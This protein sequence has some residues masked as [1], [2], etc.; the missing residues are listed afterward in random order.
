MDKYDPFPRAYQLDAIAQEDDIVPAT[1]VKVDPLFDIEEESDTPEVSTAPPLVKGTPEYDTWKKTILDKVRHDIFKVREEETVPEAVEKAMVNMVEELVSAFHDGS[2]SMAVAEFF[3][4]IVLTTKVPVVTKARP[5]VAAQKPAM[6][7]E[8]QKMEQQKV[9]LPS[10]SNYSSPVLLVKK[11]DGTIRFCIDYRRLNSITVRD[12]YPLPK[13]DSM[14]DRLGGSKYFASFDCQSGYHQIR[15]TDRASKVSA[16]AT[17]DGLFEWVCMPFGLTNAPATFQRSMD[18]ALS[19]VSR[20]CAMVYIDDVLVHSSSQ[21]EHIEN[22]QEVL[23]CFQRVNLKLKLSKCTFFATEV[24]FLGHVIGRQGIKMDPEKIE[25]VLNW[26]IPTSVKELQSFLGLVNY[27]RDFVKR[28]AAL[29]QPLYAL[30]AT[31]VGK[32]PKFTEIFLEEHVKAFEELRIAVTTGPM[33]YYPD[34]AKPFRL[35]SDAHPHG[36]AAILSQLDGEG[37]DRPIAFASSAMDSGMRKRYDLMINQSLTATEAECLGMIFGMRHFRSYLYG[38][39]FHFFTDHVAL[40]WIATIKDPSGKMARWLATIQEMDF[41]IQHVPGKSIQHCDALSRQRHPESVGVLLA[42]PV[43]GPP[44]VQDITGWTSEQFF[45]TAWNS[46]KHN[47]GPRPAPSDYDK[48]KKVKPVQLP[49][50]AGK[51]YQITSI[52]VETVVDVCELNSI[53]PPDVAFWTRIEE[54]PAEFTPPAAHIALVARHTAYADWNSAARNKM[55]LM[56]VTVIDTPNG[57]EI[58]TGLEKW[59][60]EQCLRVLYRPQ[61]ETQMSQ[62]AVINM[63]EKVDDMIEDEPEE[64]TCDHTKAQRDTY[65]TIR[66]YTGAS[67][68]NGFEARYAPS[69]H[70]TD[71][72]TVN[73]STTRTEGVNML[74]QDTTNFRSKLHQIYKEAVQQGYTVTCMNFEGQIDGL[75]QMEMDE[76]P[77]A[78]DKPPPAKNSSTSGKKASQ[79]SEIPKVSEEEKIELGNTAPTENE[80]Y[81]A[82]SRYEVEHL[83][84]LQATDPVFGVIVQYLKDIKINDKTV[85]DLQG[86]KKGVANKL[87]L[88]L[89]QYILGPDNRLWYNENPS[90]IQEIGAQSKLCIPVCQVERLLDSFHSIGH[91]GVA[92]TN[93]AIRARFHWWGMVR[94]IKKHAEACTLCQKK[95]GLPGDYGHMEPI[96][97]RGRAMLV[98]C[99]H[100]GPLLETVHGFLH[101]L[102]FT[103]HF[104]RCVE[105]VAVKDLEAETT[106]RAFIDH[107]VLRWGVPYRL[108]TDQGTTYTSDT[109]RALCKML[110]VEKIFTTAQHPQANGKTE[111]YNRTMKSILAKMVDVTMRN[112]DEKLPTIQWAYNTVIHPATGFTPHFL[113]YGFEP[114][115]PADLQYELE[116][117][118]YLPATLRES[119][120]LMEETYAAAVAEANEHATDT[121]TEAMRTYNESHKDPD[122][123]FSVGKE[124]WFYAADLAAPQKLLLPWIGPFTIKERVSHNTF[125]LYDVKTQTEF[126]SLVS[127]RRLK[128]YIRKFRPVGA[129]PTVSENLSE[130]GFDLRKENKNASELISAHQEFI[131]NRRS[132]LA[133]KKFIEDAK[134]Q[135]KAIAENK[136]TAAKALKE[137]KHK[138]L[139]KKEIT[140]QTTAKK[141]AVV[142]AAEVIETHAAQRY[143]KLTETDVASEIITTIPVVAP[144]AMETST[145]SATVTTEAARVVPTSS[146]KMTLQ[147]KLSDHNESANALNHTVIRV[148]KPVTSNNSKLGS[149]AMK[150]VSFADPV[151]SKEY[152]NREYQDSTLTSTTA[153]NSKEHGTSDL[154]KS[155]AA[156]RVGMSDRWLAHSAKFRD[157]RE[158]SMEEAKNAT[159]ERTA[160]A[161]KFT[162]QK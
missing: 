63:V 116:I 5:V 80:F 77:T 38:R 25:K 149:A 104:S 70:I 68:T 48:E 73:T 64:K 44:L 140:A 128:P 15:L 101:I 88:T 99:D 33:L 142:K 8:M 123:H 100:A 117:D 17:P 138:L 87:K 102:V 131:N 129:P 127:S 105:L 47:D 95:R 103:D 34:F 136:L 119:V 76:E 56:P 19:S 21:M 145:N 55:A 146:E 23:K 60:A 98:S 51:P 122:V 13:I 130:D 118:H 153:L 49:G 29:S 81:T 93:R 124:V 114:Q 155:K 35:T 2:S 134:M 83:V 107:V 50:Q 97:S 78:D 39:Q 115:L 162:T 67:L 27:Y 45:A 28:Y 58:D 111:R 9:V 4:D 156:A 108:L 121:A 150:H 151:V 84:E 159:T 91:F 139:T 7:A 154:M 31:K 141:L 132:Y 144:L 74:K 90:E 106:A 32:K 158:L 41:V 110:G 79:S 75:D 85:V 94:D 112:W 109:F 147:R 82:V 62:S 46:Q 160:R 24:K 37:N 54:K 72:P 20:R 1:P 143:I 40:K 3:H 120:E 57:R 14:F 42:P 61:H 133:A 71:S 22:I 135:E 36:V 66:Q 148:K 126:E 137:D 6:A 157:N 59:A 11:K 10:A 65:D 69:R 152:P 86:L 12:V 26:P 113:M 125:R 30:A 161:R 92:K 18:I 96:L 52:P 16:F 43:N 89:T 53:S